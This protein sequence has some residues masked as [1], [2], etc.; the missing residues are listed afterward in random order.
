MQTIL[1]LP[2]LILIILVVAF[3][4]ILGIINFWH[5]KKLSLLKAFFLTSK[6]GNDLE[7]FVRSLTNSQRNLQDQQLNF[8]KRLL[9]NETILES[10]IQKVSLVKFN[11][12]ADAGGNLSFCLALLDKKDNGII[13]TSMHGREQNRIYAKKITRGS[14]DIAFTEEEKRAIH[15]AQKPINY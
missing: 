8:E 9:A 4:I 12:F 11:P 15:E 7:T 5:I 3:S 10:S 6:D 2:L 14:N 13:I 1:N